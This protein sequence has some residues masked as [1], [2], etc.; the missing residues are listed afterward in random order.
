MKCIKNDWAAHESWLIQ[1]FSACLLLG[2]AHSQV[3]CRQ[4]PHHS[5]Q[6]LLRLVVG[7]AWRWCRWHLGCSQ[8]GSQRGLTK[9]SEHWICLKKVTAGKEGLFFFSFFFVMLLLSI[10]QLSA[11]FL[12]SGIYF[13]W[14]FCLPEKGKLISQMQCMT[15]SHSLRRSAPRLPR[16]ETLRQRQAIQPKIY[17]AL[18]SPGF[19]NLL[20][21]FSLFSSSLTAVLIPNPFQPS[22]SNYPHRAWGISVI[23]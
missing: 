9:H 12:T 18:I 10:T 14:F 13:K 15:C 23:N 22:C 3:L 19:E 4:S 6:W 11:E 8:P 1:P 16:C 5:Q 2:A 7:T 17:S 21:D 20:V